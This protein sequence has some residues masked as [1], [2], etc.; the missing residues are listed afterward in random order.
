MPNILLLVLERPHST[1]ENTFPAHTPGDKNCCQLSV[2]P[3]A[4]DSSVANPSC[5]ASSLAV[6][7]LR[8]HRPYGIRDTSGRKR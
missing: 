1:L 5:H 3:R 8:P 6:W 2:G 7:A 4:K